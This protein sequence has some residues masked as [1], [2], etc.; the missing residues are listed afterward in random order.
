MD[1]FF[2]IIEP[3]IVDDYIHI[4]YKSGMELEDYRRL[5]HLEFA[6]NELRFPGYMEHFTKKFKKAK[7]IGIFGIA[8][9][10][11]LFLLK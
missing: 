11:V 8:L 6:A 1:D 5:R 10:V 4:G 9:G 2:N 3:M 7:R